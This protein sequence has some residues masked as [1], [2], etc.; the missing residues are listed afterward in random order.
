MK[1]NAIIILL[2]CI[3]ACTGAYA[4]SITLRMKRTP[5]EQVLHAIEKKSR[6]TFLYS[7]EVT[8]HAG[9][10]DINVKNAGIKD[11]LAQCFNRQPISYNIVGDTVIVLRLVANGPLPETVNGRVRNERDEA[12]GGITVQWKGTGR[13]ITTD[14]KG[15][16]SMPGVP[17]DAVLVFS[18]V[19]IET[20]ELAANRR[21][22][23]EV[24]VRMKISE[25]SPVDVV[26]NGY[27]ELNTRNSPGSFTKTNNDLINRSVSSNI[28][29]R[30]LDV[31]SG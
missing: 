11:V 29:E 27:Q 6:Y 12:Q 28:I 10:V 16:F 4:Q 7:S 2:V 9:P 24:A 26:S 5:L 30:L 13:F 8:D 20:M 3:H 14:D 15:F 31:N 21:P 22:G 1:R 19:N 17:G 18:G 23:W 25:L